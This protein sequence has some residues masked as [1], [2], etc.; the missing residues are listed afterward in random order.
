MVGIEVVFRACCGDLSRNET[1]REGSSIGCSA[2]AVKQ[3]YVQL[4]LV[5]KCVVV[6]V[7]VD[8]NHNDGRG[9]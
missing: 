7:K 6:L 1:Y 8:G 5:W 9:S 3:L 2:A 4:N